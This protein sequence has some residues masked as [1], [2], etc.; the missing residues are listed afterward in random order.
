M[1][2]LVILIKQCNVSQTCGTW[3]EFVFSPLP[4]YW[5]GGFKGWS[6]NTSGTP[7]CL[8][9]R[10]DFF[11]SDLTEG[12]TGS[13]WAAGEEEEAPPSQWESG[14]LLLL[15][16]SWGPV[17]SHQSLS[18]RDLTAVGS[19]TLTLERIWKENRRLL[20]SFQMKHFNLNIWDKGWVGSV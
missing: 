20:L 6:L 19:Q 2:L 5:K 17:I 10:W 8:T 18:T 7:S 16:Q 12:P 1:H 11:Y 9:A 15:S 4:A 14:D 13:V 3:L